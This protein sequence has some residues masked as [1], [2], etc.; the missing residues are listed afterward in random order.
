M[1]LRNLASDYVHYKQALGIRFN[2]DAYHLERFCLIAGGDKLLREVT[3]EDVQ[4]FLGSASEG[5]P[6]WFRKL[7]V[8]KGV[9]RFA[10]ACGET[11]LL[12]L[13]NK[14]PQ[15]TTTFVPY[16]FSPYELARLFAAIPSFCAAR[17]VT[18]NTA[19]LVFLLLYGAGLR[20]GEAL[21]L[22][23]NDVDIEQGILKV[24]ATKF[25]K[26]RLVPVGGG[27][28]RELARYAEWRATERFSIQTDS[29]FVDR[30]GSALKDPQIRAIFEDLRRQCKL[31]KPETSQVPR[32]H[33]M[34]H[35]FAVHRLITGY[36]RGENVQALLSKLATYLGHASVESTQVY[37]TMTPILL[38]LAS[39][40]FAAYA[41]SEVPCEA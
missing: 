26:T 16:I 12:P 2:T 21:H 25:Y 39:K 15:G 4:T 32:M 23:K 11:T 17:K 34:R 14:R 13:P 38:E 29:F 37:L 1:K 22:A 9:N 35:S 41:F 20:L 31:V 18:P 30:K 28:Q 6:Y 10:A 24:R 19:R 40:R 33:D 7:A 8:L 27:L 36:Q 3:P 5:A